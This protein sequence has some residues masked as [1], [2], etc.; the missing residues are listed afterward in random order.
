MSC[1]YSFDQNKKNSNEIQKLLEKVIIGSN[2]LDPESLCI[3]TGKY[4]WEITVNCIVVKDCGNIIDAVLNASVCALMDM[5]KPIVVVETSGVV[6]GEKMIPLSIAHTPLS[7][8]FG[9]YENSIFLDPTREEEKCEETRITIS[10]NVYYE[11]CSIHKP[12]GKGVTDTV[13]SSILKVC[14]KQVK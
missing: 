3:L 14:Q 4:V 10:M 6:L 12:G 5:K 13:I 11:I 7:F 9:L 1:P 8:T 2:S